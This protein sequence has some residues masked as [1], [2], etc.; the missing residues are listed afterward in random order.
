MTAEVAIALPKPTGFRILVEMLEMGSVT[1]GG[2]HI[3]DSTKKLEETAGIVAKVVAMGPD[4]Y[5]DAARFPAGPW[6]QVGDFVVMKSY[7]GARLKVG[8]KEYRLI[9]DDTIEATVEDPSQVE[10]A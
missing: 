2:I 8:G 10:R 9:N 1:K 3:P 7:S 5:L 6:C 4:A